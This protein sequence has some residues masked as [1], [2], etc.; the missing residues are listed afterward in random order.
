MNGGEEKRQEKK[1]LFKKEQNHG[2]SGV[3]VR[4]SDHHTGDSKLARKVLHILQKQSVE[5][6]NCLERTSYFRIPQSEIQA[7]N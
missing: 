7:Q 5:R 2:K 3:G 6:D 1:E 4:S